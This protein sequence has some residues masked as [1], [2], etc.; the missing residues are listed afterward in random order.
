MNDK[1]SGYLTSF[2]LAVGALCSFAGGVPAYGAP[3]QYTLNVDGGNTVGSIGGAVFT[4]GIMILTF[5]GDTNDIIPFDVPASGTVPETVGYVLLKGQATVFIYD[6]ANGA[7]YQATFLPSGGI[8]VG[9]D[10]TNNGFGFGSGGV[11]P[12][13]PAF[14][15]PIG[16]P[17][18][19]LPPGTG[20]LAA[21]NLATPLSL[22]GYGVG[23]TAFPLTCA[24]VGP[25]LATTA[26]DLILDHQGIAAAS[27]Q[28]QLLEIPF[29][30]FS[31]RANGSLTRSGYFS[32][33]GTVA[34]GTGGAPFNPTT[35]AIALQFGP[36]SA[37]LPPGSLQVT[38]PG[39]FTY[40]GTV[41]G[42]PFTLH[43]TQVANGVYRLR[44]AASH[45]NLRGT[46][47]PVTVTLTIGSN[48][49]ST[50]VRV[51]TDN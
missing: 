9:V 7:S 25:P 14:P 23:C 48:T 17:Q 15:G 12:S 34:L 21:W 31:A 50:T 6:L 28:V 40:T 46:T 30:S 10:N 51:Q 36:F 2:V 33:Q 18:L 39:A 41:S 4:Q 42:S 45:V 8:Y 3:I 13:D 37:S 26:G 44:A 22:V 16:Y 29:S 49:G 24:N 1:A 20:T 11:P 19:F 32:L 35:D 38:G 27:L 47:N 5:T 43:L